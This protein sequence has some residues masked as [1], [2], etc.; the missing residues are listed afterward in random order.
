M[1]AKSFGSIGFSE[2]GCGV[3][4]SSIGWGGLNLDFYGGGNSG[5]LPNILKV[6]IPT[7][8]NGLNLFSWFLCM[9]SL[10]N[11]QSFSSIDT[12]FSSRADQ[13]D[14]SFE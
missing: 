3:A 12:V 8:L 14:Y 9:T 10:R 2:T 5:L 4:E 13:F 1:W 11:W 7:W 6:T